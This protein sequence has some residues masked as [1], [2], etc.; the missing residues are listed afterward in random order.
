MNNHYN[1]IYM[2]INKINNKKY[3]G[4]AKNFNRRHR[5]HISS[6]Y[7]EKEKYHYSLPF[8]CA[9]R[10][11]GIENFD[12]KILAENIESKE[13]LDEYEK[14][15]IKRYDTLA[16]NKNGYNIADGGSNG[17]AFAGK[18]ENEMKEIKNKISK[19]RIEN[20]LAKGYNNPMYGK[21]HSDESKQ[22]MSKKAKERL[23]NKENNPRYGTG[24]KI[25]QWSNDNK[26]IIKIYN[27][28]NE[29]SSEFNVSNTMICNVCNFW[30]INCNKEE[31][32]KTHKNR[33]SKTSKGFI[34]KY[35]KD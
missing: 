28:V 23:K 15:F 19:I 4:Q 7:N 5:K 26:Y 20:G 13:K 16:N 29:V 27:N 34:W 14:F 30:K 18:T 21:K 35:H 24:N 10:K 1:C 17:N 3:V 2:Y 31:W 6:S 8:H 22:K 32:F 12:I 33:P 9:I 11:Y 25:E